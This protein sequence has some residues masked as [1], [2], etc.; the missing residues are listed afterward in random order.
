MIGMWIELERIMAECGIRI[1]GSAVHDFSYAS[2][3]SLLQIKMHLS[4]LV[5]LL[6]VSTQVAEVILQ[7]QTENG[8]LMWGYRFSLQ[9]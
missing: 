9:K 8:P 6:D 2:L 1:G 3:R 7:A 5:M 4:L